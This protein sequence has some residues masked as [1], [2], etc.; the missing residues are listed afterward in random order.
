MVSYNVVNDSNVNCF[1]EQSGSTKQ[2]WQFV[3]HCLNEF[4]SSGSWNNVNR[5][6]KNIFQIPDLL[7]FETNICIAAYGI[8][9]SVNSGE[10]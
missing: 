6:D 3:N 7:P 2:I 8:L 10:N 5:L 9:I 4:L 1:S